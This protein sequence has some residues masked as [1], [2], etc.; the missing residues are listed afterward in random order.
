MEGCYSSGGFRAGGFG[1]EFKGRVV[2]PEEGPL[3]FSKLA[4]FGTL[5]PEPP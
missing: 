1:S 5:N 2:N 3:C 4:C